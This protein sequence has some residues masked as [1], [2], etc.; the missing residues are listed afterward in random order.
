MARAFNGTSQYLISDLSST[1][2]PCTISCLVKFNT[3]TGNQ[4]FAGINASDDDR[5][6]LRLIGN[7]AQA[8]YVNDG[9]ISA[10]AESPTIISTGIWYNICGVFNSISSRTIYVNGSNTA[11][12][13]TTVNSVNPATKVTISALRYTSGSGGTNLFTQYLNGEIAEVGIWS[14]ALTA[15]EIASLA[16][17]M[18]CDKV[19]PQNLVFYAPLVRDLVDQKG[20]LAITNNNGATVANHPRVYA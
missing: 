1:S 16:N 17:G 14:A 18:T 20:G 2:V 10:N 8:V 5:C 15:A 11:T 4:N 12:N 19:R 9:V 13:T 7:K 3:V 6:V